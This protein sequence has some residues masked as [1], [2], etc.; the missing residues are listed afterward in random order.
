MITS[1]RADSRWASRRHVKTILA[2]AVGLLAGLGSTSAHAGG[3]PTSGDAR[4]FQV[5]MDYR[6]PPPALDGYGCR[7]FSGA[8]P[9]S[10]STC[11]MYVAGVAYFTG[12]VI[13]V[14]HYNLGAWFDE[15]GRLAYEGRPTFDAVVKGCGK[16]T[17]QVEETEGWIDYTMLDTTTGGAKGFNRWRVLPETAT[18]EL[19]GRL[20]GGGGVNNWMSYTL[21]KLD[22]GGSPGG[23]REGGRGTFTGTLTCRS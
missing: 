7:G 11:R 22:G 9:V 23:E 14:Q 6:E 21:G 2:A 5:V 8:P 4:T 19:A 16:G 3:P 18:G 10:L 12:G 1:A 15:K 20:L 17:F 13:G